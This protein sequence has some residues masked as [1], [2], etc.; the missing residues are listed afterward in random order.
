MTPNPSFKRTRSGKPALAL[1]SFWGQ[2]RLASTSRL[3]Q[4]L[5]R[6]QYL[7][8]N[9]ESFVAHLRPS[10]DRQSTAEVPGPN[11]PEPV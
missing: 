5:G 11:M 4:T 10:Q 9:A 8:A 1:I 6:R 3:T 7:L 2:S